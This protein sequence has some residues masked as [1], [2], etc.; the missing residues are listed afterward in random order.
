MRAFELIGPV[1]F[2]P[3]SMHTAGACRVARAAW[4]ISGRDIK[5][6][7]IQVHGTFKVPEGGQINTAL[8]AGLLGYNTDND[9]IHNSI[10]DAA[11]AGVDIS[12]ENVTIEGAHNN[13]VR[14]RIS[15]ENYDQMVITGVSVGGGMIEMVDICG[16]KVSIT[17]DYNTLILWTPDC[18]LTQSEVYAL[19]IGRPPHT[20]E[21]AES[22]DG[23]TQLVLYKTKKDIPEDLAEKLAKLPLVYRCT[24]HDM[25]E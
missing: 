13:T 18:L 14:Y 9:R 24:R 5:K 20:I 8:V 21:T 19:S 25:F 17:G 1:M 3:S 23:S 11:A 2:G 7:M 22:E 12:W 6:A 10:E 4:Q 16:A 15:G